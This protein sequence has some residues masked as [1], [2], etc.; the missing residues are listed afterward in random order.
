MNNIILVGHGKFAI[1][2]E[3]TI[4]LI[5]GESNLTTIEF[6]QGMSREQLEE[7]IVSKLLPTNNII[8]TDII[9]GTPF[10]IS[11]KLASATTKVIYGTNISTILEVN[12][13]LF[14]N[15]EQIIEDSQ[16]TIGCFKSGGSNYD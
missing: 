9:G 12:N 10:N 14:E 3:S 11:A 13:C 15:V 16:Q 2:L 1:G 6:K 7:E 4:K 8:M 5:T